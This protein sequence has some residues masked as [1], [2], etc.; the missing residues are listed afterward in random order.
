MRQELT[1][2]KNEKVSGF[3]TDD[4]I[5]GNP[6]SFWSYVKKKP[7]Q[8]GQRA[9]LKRPSVCFGYKNL[10]FSPLFNKPWSNKYWY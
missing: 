10:V 2:A 5:E 7:G 4:A 3:L 9:H 6:K 1:K 8:P